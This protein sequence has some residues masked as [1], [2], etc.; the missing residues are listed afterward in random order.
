MRFNALGPDLPKA[1]KPLL[2][3]INALS[4]NTQAFF[5]ALGVVVGALVLRFFVLHAVNAHF[6]EEQAR[7]DR[8][9]NNALLIGSLQTQLDGYKAFAQAYGPLRDS[10]YS[11]ARDLVRIGDS[12][13]NPKATDT[14]LQCLT[15]SDDG[16]YY[17]ANGVGKSY[18]S[19][20][21]AI[22]TINKAGLIALPVTQSDKG[23][24][25]EFTIKIGRAVNQ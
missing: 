23:T 8:A 21:T 19:Y 10:G 2:P 22:H 20:T 24:R 1:R 13:P 11:V 25:Q 17:T 6:A 5:A 18:D 12:W 14:S 9:K 16:L 7:L 3:G 15:P 4:T